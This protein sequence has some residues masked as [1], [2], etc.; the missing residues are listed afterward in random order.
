[1]KVDLLETDLVKRRSIPLLN[2]SRESQ[3]LTPIKMDNE[4][5]I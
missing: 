2:L 5:M 3:K 1:M 4:Y